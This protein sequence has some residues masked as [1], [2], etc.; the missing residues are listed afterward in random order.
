MKN[1]GMK[2]QATTL[3]PAP[4]NARAFAHERNLDWRM[5]EEIGVRKISAR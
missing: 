2:T 1:K 3:R 5:L 4:I